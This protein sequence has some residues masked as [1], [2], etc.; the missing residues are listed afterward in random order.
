MAH[1]CGIE[2]AVVKNKRRNSIIANQA[3]V[4]Q[5]ES[6]N[7]Q[8]PVNMQRRILMGSALAA[9]LV[10][11]RS[12]MADDGE[13]TKTPNDPFIVLL[14]GIYE[15]CCGSGTKSNLGLTKVNL[16]DGTYSTTQI[17]SVFGIESTGDTN[18]RRKRSARFT[19]EFAGHLCA[20]D[21]PGGAIAMTFN[22]VPLATPRV[23]RFCA[24]P[25]GHNGL[26]LE[27]TFELMIIE[28]T[29]VY[30]AFQGRA[31]PHG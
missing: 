11:P 14:S 2:T 26:F 30:G 28:A 15:R 7:G 4:N 1:P 5:R 17:Y 13:D 24:V 21:L 27:G 25:D 3:L 9:L 19:V 16:N 6:G 20:Y 10:S 23:Q 22:S 18:T 8:E 31:Q 12:I 29:G